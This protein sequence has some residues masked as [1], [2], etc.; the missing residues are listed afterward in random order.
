MDILFLDIAGVLYDHR[1]PE[2]QRAAESAAVLA[3]PE[4]DVTSVAFTRYLV[5]IYKVPLFNRAAIGNLNWF[6]NEHRNIRIVIT[7]GWRIGRSPWSIAHILAAHEFSKYIIG[8]TSSKHDGTAVRT[9]LSHHYLDVDNMTRADEIQVW[10]NTNAYLVRKF[11][12]FDDN[13]DGLSDRFKSQY[14][15]VDDSVLLS[16][17]NVRDAKEC[18]SK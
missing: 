4:A 9:T 6:L 13:D 7:S 15:K 18:L 11:V 5:Q 8:K 17:Q 10:L 3:Y 14:V 2:L 16:V 1:S 12:I